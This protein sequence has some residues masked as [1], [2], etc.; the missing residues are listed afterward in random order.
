MHG[1]GIE[2]PTRKDGQR[3]H[4]WRT[5]VRPA[6]IIKMLATTPYNTGLSALFAPTLGILAGAQQI[7]PT[8]AAATIRDWRRG[9]RKAPQWALALLL[10]ALER[11]SSEL[12]HAKDLI[13]AEQKKMADPVDRPKSLR[14]HRCQLTDSRIGSE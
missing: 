8:A 6:P 13:R 4:H 7:T 3:S 12:D 9:K 10:E 11:R 5:G 1:I 2:G 14:N